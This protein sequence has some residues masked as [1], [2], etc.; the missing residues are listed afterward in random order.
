MA[1]PWIQNRLPVIS[2]ALFLTAPSSALIKNTISRWRPP[3]SEE[4]PDSLD[5]AGAYIGVLERLFVYFFVLNGLW[6]AVGFLIAAKSVFRFGDLRNSSDLKLTEY[7][8]IGTLLSVGLA[9]L[10]AA[11]VRA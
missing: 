1:I 6:D 7:I 9:S 8:L 5:R 11:M 2:G 3:T 10:V 4:T